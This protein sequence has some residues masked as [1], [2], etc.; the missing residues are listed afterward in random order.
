MTGLIGQVCKP[1]EGFSLLVLI[2]EQEKQAHN[3]PK[4]QRG[5]ECRKQP[6]HLRHEDTSW[7][8]V[9]KGGEHNKENEQT[10]RFCTHTTIRF[11]TNPP[12]SQN[13]FLGVDTHSF[14]WWS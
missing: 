14:V 2:V 1:C 11:T 13:T 9:L 10:L 3:R 8:H 6:P 12:T 4:E 5:R 7:C